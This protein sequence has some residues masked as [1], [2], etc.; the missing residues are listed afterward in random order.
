MKTKLFST[1]WPARDKRDISDNVK[2][3]C[4]YLLFAF[5]AYKKDCAR[6]NREW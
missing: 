3:K 6:Q 4:V 5:D 1:S 2:F